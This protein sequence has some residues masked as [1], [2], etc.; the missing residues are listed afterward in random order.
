MLFQDLTGASFSSCLFQAH[1]AFLSE[2]LIAATFHCSCLS[3]TVMQVRNKSFVS[4]IPSVRFLPQF[5][6]KWL[7]ELWKVLRCDRGLRRTLLLLQWCDRGLRSALLLLQCFIQISACPSKSKYCTELD[8]I[9][10]DLPLTL[11]VVVSVLNCKWNKW[12]R[13]GVLIYV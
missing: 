8:L 9:F 7:S 11:I 12:V 2:Q 4:L 5:P 1:T 13:A 10:E 6:V 3:C